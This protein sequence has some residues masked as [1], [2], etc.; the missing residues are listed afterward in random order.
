[1]YVILDAMNYF[2]LALFD[3]EFMYCSISLVGETVYPREIC[4]FINDED[5]NMKILKFSSLI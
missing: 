2:N 3:N 1:M 5:H 4:L